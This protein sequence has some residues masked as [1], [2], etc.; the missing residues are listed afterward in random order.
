ML[1]GAGRGFMCLAPPVCT[2]ISLGAKPS[3]CV[4]NPLKIPPVITVPPTAPS[5]EFLNFLYGG[6][7]LREGIPSGVISWYL[8]F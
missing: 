3:V 5:Q 8:C 7:N 6:G 1:C 2:L 4:A